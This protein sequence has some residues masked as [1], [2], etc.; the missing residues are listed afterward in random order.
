MVGRLRSTCPLGGYELRG[1][2]EKGVCLGST[3]WGGRVVVAEV[4]SVWV[5]LCGSAGLKVRV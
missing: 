5:G 4:C 1:F 3:W 2:G